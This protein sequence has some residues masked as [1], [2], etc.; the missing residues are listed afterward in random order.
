MRAVFV[1][2]SCCALAASTAGCKSVPEYMREVNPVRQLKA[3]ADRAL[4]VFVHA[5]NDRAELPAHVMDDSLTFLGSALP[6]THFSVV[7]PPGK[8]QFIVFSGDAADAVVADLYPGLV[9]FIELTPATAPGPARFTFKTS[10]RGTNIFP[11]KE[12]WVDDTSQFRVDPF[13][14]SRQMRRSA[15]RHRPIRGTAPVPTGAS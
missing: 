4:V 3:P 11:Y 6:G 15:R 13:E 2:L 9:Y 1:F 7:R 14:S 10:A 12:E 5:S 8:Q